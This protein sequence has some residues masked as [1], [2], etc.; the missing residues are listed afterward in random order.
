[1]RLLDHFSRPLSETRPWTAFHSR[2]ANAISDHLNEV[3]PRDFYAGPEVRWRHQGDSVAIELPGGGDRTRPADDG[4][5]ALLDPPPTRTVAFDGRLDVVEVRVL[6][7]R[8]DGPVLVGVV[9][10]VSPANKDAWDRRAAFVTKTEGYVAAGVG[11][12]VADIVTSHSR[13]L[14]RDL[15]R[16]FGEPDPE[17]DP[18]YAAAYRLRSGPS[19][20][21]DVWYE[22][23]AVGD[24]LPDLPLHLKDGP[25]VLLPLDETYATACRRD[26]IDDPA[27]PSP[28]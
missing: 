20:E 12:L 16:R 18:T 27:E 19:S 28:V 5:T 10:V 13:S 25:T 26:R 6:E 9:E 7:E 24:D 17:A 21:V 14:H 15:M 2:W 23:L 3:L 8:E 22:R 11:T 1:M 4:A